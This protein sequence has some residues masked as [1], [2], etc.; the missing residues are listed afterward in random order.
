MKDASKQNQAA[1]NQHTEKTALE[2]RLR[3]MAA[4]NAGFYP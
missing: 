1:V 2:D 4:N 3:E